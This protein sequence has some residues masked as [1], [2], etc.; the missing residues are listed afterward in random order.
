[1]DEL[2]RLAGLV[3]PEGPDRRWSST[4]IDGRSALRPPARVDIAVA[5]ATPGL[6]SALAWR[7]VAHGA[8][9][10]AFDGGSADWRGAGTA[11]WFAETVGAGRHKHFP[12]T[13][14]ERQPCERDAAWTR[15]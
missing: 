7:A 13:E 11:R 5:S 2:I 14:R 6:I 3:G 12:S 8:R 15:D 10:I 9:V 4:P 1:V